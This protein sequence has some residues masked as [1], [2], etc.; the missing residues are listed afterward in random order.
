MHRTLRESWLQGLWPLG[1]VQIGTEE[2]CGSGKET[3]M[4]CG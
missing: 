3:M 2:H 4:D 1:L